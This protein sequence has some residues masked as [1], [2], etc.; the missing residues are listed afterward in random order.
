[1]ARV[2][3]CR[4]ESR[5]APHGIRTGKKFEEDCRA[6]TEA[7]TCNPCLPIRRYIQAFS[8]DSGRSRHGYVPKISKAP[9]FVS[10]PNFP[11]AGACP[12][13][14]VSARLSQPR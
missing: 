11:L 5:Q 12:R 2:E 8:D 10:F 1:M 13:T 14:P 6:P 3:S 7:E 9:K 4:D